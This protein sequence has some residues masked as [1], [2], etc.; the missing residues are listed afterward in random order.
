MS[1]SNNEFQYR[2]PFRINEPRTL[3]FFPV[4]HVMP[5]AFLFFLGILTGNVLAF[6]IAGV[7]WF[8]VIRRTEER[9]PKG[10]LLARLYWS[11]IAIFLR[12]SKWFPDPMKRN[13]YQ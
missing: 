8:I 6:F 10:Y 5:P 9:Y 1:Q 11:G 4:H 3:I 13:Y 7:A 2:V 12:Q